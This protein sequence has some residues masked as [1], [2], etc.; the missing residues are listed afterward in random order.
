MTHKFV[1]GS[2]ASKPKN[3]LS[4]QNYCTM[5]KYRQR[6]NDKTLCTYRKIN[7]PIEQKMKTCIFLEPFNAYKE[8]KK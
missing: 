6:V 1:R 4:K 3:R 7:K 2:E 5:C 8:A